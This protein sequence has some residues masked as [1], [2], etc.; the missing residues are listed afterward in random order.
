M[1]PG[2]LTRAAFGLRRGQAEPEEGPEVSRISRPTATLH[3]AT[4]LEVHGLG[5]TAAVDRQQ[6][7]AETG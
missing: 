2:E 5:R 1:T 7:R 6:P 4:L 3:D